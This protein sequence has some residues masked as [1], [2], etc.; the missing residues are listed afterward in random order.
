MTALRRTSPQT[1]PRSAATSAAPRNDPYAEVV[2]GGLKTACVA[3]AADA[4]MVDD[5]FAVRR[6]TRAPKLVFA[7]NGHAIAF[8]AT[9]AHS[10]AVRVRRHRPRRRPAGRDRLA[11]HRPPDPG[12]QRHHRFHPRRRPAAA[13]KPARLP[14]GRD[15]RGQRALCADPAGQYPGLKIAGR[16]NGYFN[17]TTR[18]RSATRSTLGRRHR[19]RRP[20]RPVRVRVLRAQQG[21]PQ[22]RLGRDL[23]R[24][25]QFRHRRLRA[26]AGLDA[27]ILARMALPPGARAQA[28]VLALRGHQSAGDVP[29]PARSRKA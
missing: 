4:L 24:L 28:A 23:R 27:E 20:Q 19:V 13:Q 2:V 10:A 1:G 8:A 29:D 15:G 16:R 9:N 22:R 12:A 3:R 26:R 14:A 11:P 5:C 18:R 6:G 21:A 7:S 17:A 25:L